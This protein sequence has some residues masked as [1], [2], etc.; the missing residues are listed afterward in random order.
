MSSQ[1]PT[2]DDL[3]K[4]TG[5]PVSEPPIAD[6]QDFKVEAARSPRPPWTQPLPKLILAGAVLLPIAMIAGL[7]LLGSHQSSQSRTET[8]D[9]P[10]TE[11]P[12]RPETTPHELEQV[13]QENA[14]LKA[15]AALDGQ[16]RV[17][18]QT[19][20]SSERGK[21]LRVEQPKR[22]ATV[23]V[24]RSAVAP[25]ADSSYGVSRIEPPNGHRASTTFAGSS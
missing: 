19:N 8:S 4:L 17:E 5:V 10:S 22:M 18:A 20:K 23:Q 7:F 12:K 6:A 21:P 25:P 14:H 11:E 3:R 2:T 16:Q 13:R 15:K 9:P 24:S 1:P